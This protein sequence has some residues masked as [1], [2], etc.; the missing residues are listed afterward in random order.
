MNTLDRLRRILRDALHLGARAEALPADARLMG[1]LPEL[2]SMAVVTILTMLEDEF[3]IS[4]ADD[5]MS[6]DVFATLASLR[7]FV[8][9]KLAA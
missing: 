9:A 6:A 7:D 8:D 5:D 3:G 2:D 4:I 1:A